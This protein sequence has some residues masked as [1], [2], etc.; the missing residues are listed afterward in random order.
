MAAIH[1]IFFEWKSCTNLG[2]FLAYNVT[3]SILES[4]G[5]F[6]VTAD[7]DVGDSCVAVMAKYSWINFLISEVLVQNGSWHCTSSSEISPILKHKQMK[8]EGGRELST[9][10]LYW[11]RVPFRMFFESTLKVADKSLSKFIEVCNV[12]LTHAPFLQLPCCFYS[13]W[14][15][16]IPVVKEKSSKASLRPTKTMDDCDKSSF[17]SLPTP[18]ERRR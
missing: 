15:F 8:N 12:T 2:N 4:T 6:S 9:F 1:K 5:L 18:C 14:T 10:S 3:C 11:E 7:V 17:T 13:I 16:F